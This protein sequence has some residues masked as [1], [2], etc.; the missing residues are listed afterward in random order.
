M[1][2]LR[3]KLKGMLERIFQLPYRNAS[4]IQRVELNTDKYQ[5][6]RKKIMKYCGN[7][8]FKND[9][10]IRQRKNAEGTL[11]ISKKSIDV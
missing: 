3:L 9:D 2:L 6:P 10:M 5:Y 1:K 7:E 4:D 11:E 8:V